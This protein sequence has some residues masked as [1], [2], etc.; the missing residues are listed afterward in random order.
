M[1][2]VVVGWV[3]FRAETFDAAFRMTGSMFGLADLGLGGFGSLALEVSSWSQLI[4]GSAYWEGK[5]QLIYL[6]AASFF[7]LALPNT[8]E[9]FSRYNPVVDRKYP[10]HSRRVTTDYT[11]KLLLSKATLRGI[12]QWRL[13][14]GSLLVSAFIAVWSLI[15]LFGGEVAAFVCFQF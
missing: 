13:G 6:I 8:Q 3:F 10:V 9:V 11:L 15:F 1:L 4:G 2:A 12:Y 14:I 5:T 7:C